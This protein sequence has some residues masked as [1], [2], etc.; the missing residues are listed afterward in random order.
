MTLMIDDRDLEKSPESQFGQPSHGGAPLAPI[1]I[2]GA[3]IVLLIAAGAWW[4]SRRAQQSE[5]AVNQSAR[6]VTAT[7]APIDKPAERPVVL[8]PLNEMDAFL[9]PLLSALSTRPELARWL[10]TDDLI[11]QIASAI[12][13]AGDGNSPARDFRMLAPKGPIATKGRASPGAPTTRTLRR[14]V[15]ERTIDPGSYRRFDSLVT[16]ATSIDPAAV[17]GIYRT[18]RPRLNEAYQAM[19]NPNR[20]VDNALRNAIDIVLDT[21]VV[22][23]PIRIVEGGGAAWDYADPELESLRP[24]Q[25][26]LVRM[27]PENAEKVLV[28]L[29]GLKNAL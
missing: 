20:D 16:A 11:R 14:G 18:I 15:D 21:P 1:A 4:M 8:P 25:K 17:A 27:G 22:Q 7:D 2:A 29:R 28:W 24:T 9:R 23:G 10:A 5:G 3:L 26:Q 13:Q 19:G 12:D 6:V